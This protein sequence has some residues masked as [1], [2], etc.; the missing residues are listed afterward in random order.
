[1]AR[2]SDDGGELLEERIACMWLATKTLGAMARE[3]GM[4]WGSD[5]QSELFEEKDRQHVAGDEDTWGN[6]KIAWDGVGERRRGR[7]VR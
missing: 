2:W 6:D 1:M 4:A 5:D 7:A 3:H